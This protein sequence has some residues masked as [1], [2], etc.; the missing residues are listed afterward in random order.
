LGTGVIGKRYRDQFAHPRGKKEGGRP[1]AEKSKKGE[2]RGETPTG[3]RKDTEVNGFHIVDPSGR[4]KEAKR[5]TEL[6]SGKHKRG[7]GAGEDEK[8]GKKKADR[9]GGEKKD[10]ARLRE[11]LSTPN[12]S[13]KKGGKKNTGLPAK[14]RKKK[15]R[16][17]RKKFSSDMRDQLLRGSKNTSCGGER[18]KKRNFVWWVKHTGGV[19]PASFQE[20]YKTKSQLTVKGKRLGI[21]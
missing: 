21:L 16:G 9:T 7:D 20:K 1:W 10:R 13:Q 15:G 5:P 4:R 14:L 2:H 6:Q 19:L 12:G 8:K 11:D 18:K 3:E 17:K